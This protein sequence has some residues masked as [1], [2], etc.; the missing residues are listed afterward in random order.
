MSSS[1]KRSL[2]AKTSDDKALIIPHRDCDRLCASVATVQCALRHCIP[3]A[4]KIGAFD[5]A[6]DVSF[7]KA[8]PNQR[9]ELCPRAKIRGNSSPVLGYD[10]GMKLLTVG[11]GDFSFSLAL[12][13]L[14]CHVVATSYESQETIQKVYVTV[15]IQATLAELESLGA[16]VIYGVDATN[17]KGTLPSALANLTFQRVIWNFPCSAV[18]KG[19]DGQN[20]E[21]EHNKTLV[22]EFVN[23]ARHLCDCQIHIN[24]K[25]KPPFNQWKIDEVV[26]SAADNLRYM[27]RVVLDRHLLPPYVPRKA[28]DRKSFPCHDACTYIFNVMENSERLRASD[29]ETNHPLGALVL[30]DLTKVDGMT[31]STLVTVTPDLIQAVRTCQF[32]ESPSKLGNYSKAKRTK[33]YNK[34][35]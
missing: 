29:E 3:C 6:L 21:M 32:R 18:T 4:Y 28:L 35:L 5:V 24:H 25:T 19:Q 15:N 23:S 17:L 14:G 11:D 27:G 20:Q 1:R 30:H 33:S 34:Y 9:P 26:V 12:A 7:C 2:D 16:E 31:P 13:R 10:Q 22:R 8:V